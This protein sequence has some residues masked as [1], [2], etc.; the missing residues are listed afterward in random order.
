MFFIIQVSIFRKGKIGNVNKFIK[1]EIYQFYL[2]SSSINGNVNT[3][4]ILTVKLASDSDEA[5]N[6]LLQ[7]YWFYSVSG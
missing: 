7:V 4:F 3:V 1:K 2:E 5:I 6:M